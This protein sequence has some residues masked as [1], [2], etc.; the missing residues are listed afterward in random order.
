MKSHHPLRYS[1]MSIWWSI[2]PR[3]PSQ[4]PLSLDDTNTTSY[5]SFTVRGVR[6]TLS[7][8]SLVFFSRNTY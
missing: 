3:I 5:F 2:S 4:Y 6:Q 8:T 1:N 7:S